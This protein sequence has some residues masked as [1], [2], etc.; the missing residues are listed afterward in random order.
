MKGFE[1]K[2]NVYAENQGEAVLASDAIKDFITG[3]ANKGI[4][5]T[6]SKITSAVRKWKDNYFV[7]NYFK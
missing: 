5:V 1:V 7:T 2:F 6:A 4:P 3:M